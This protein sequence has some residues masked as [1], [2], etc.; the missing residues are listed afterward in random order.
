METL[1]NPAAPSP[2]KLIHRPTSRKYFPA[3][4]LRISTQLSACV[5]IHNVCQNYKLHV[6]LPFHLQYGKLDPQATELDVVNITNHVKNN[7]VESYNYM[8]LTFEPLR[9]VSVFMF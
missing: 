5:F 3:D 1:S 2:G 8:D 7:S 9:D 6:L 4:L